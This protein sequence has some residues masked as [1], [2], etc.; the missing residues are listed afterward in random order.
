MAKFFTK[1]WCEAY[2][3]AINNS[4]AY[5]E[6]GKTWEGYFYFVMEPSG[7]VK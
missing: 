2:K 4:A 7:P 3:D 1:E 5:E 6:A